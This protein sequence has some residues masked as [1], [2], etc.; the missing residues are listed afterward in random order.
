LQ[1]FSIFEELEAFIKQGLH[2]NEPVIRAELTN[3]LKEKMNATPRPNSGE[4]ITILLDYQCH[5]WHRVGKPEMLYGFTEQ[6]SKK[7]PII[8]STNPY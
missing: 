2:V 3:A 8:F 6:P 1:T 5:Y 4:C 7:T